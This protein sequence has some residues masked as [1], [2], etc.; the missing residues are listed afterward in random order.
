MEKMTKNGLVG[1]KRPIY[2]QKWPK[3]GQANAKWQKMAKMAKNG[4]VAQCGNYMIF[5]SLRFYVKSILGSSRSAESDILTHQ[6]LW[7]L[8]FMNFLYFMKVEIHQINKIQSPKYGKKGISRA[9]G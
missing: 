3:N 8:I 2:D 9:I 6:S 5:L 4:Q 7:I 1:Q